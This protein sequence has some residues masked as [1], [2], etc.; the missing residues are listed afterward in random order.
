MKQNSLLVLLIISLVAITVGLKISSSDAG[1]SH[2]NKKDLL[3]YA[4]A[5]VDLNKINKVVI[6]TATDDQSVT[7]D[8]VG[9]EWRVKEG[10]DYPANV[11]ALTEFL[12]ELQSTRVVELKTAKV[13]HHSKLNLAALDSPN[14]NA[15][16]L[17]LHW[18]GNEMALL[19]GKEMGHGKGRYVRFEDSPQTYLVDSYLQ[20]SDSVNDWL[21]PKVFAVD[22]SD[23]R[24]VTLDKAGQVEFSALRPLKNLAVE[25]KASNEEN[26]TNLAK[27][28]VEQ[29]LN[30]S[31]LDEK[32]DSEK[33]V[34]ADHF[35]LV[36]DEKVDIELKSPSIIDG[37]VRNLISLELR[38]VEQRTKLDLLKLTQ[39]VFVEYQSKLGNTGRLRVDFY[40]SDDENL[41]FIA[42]DNSKWLIE[43][44]KNDYNKLAIDKNDLVSNTES[45]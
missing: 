33:S 31:K 8:L 27:K 40:S 35:E 41:Y 4:S 30:L 45:E 43:I 29:T 37:F 6:E 3:S 19:I 16:R 25:D 18:P 42:I 1:S 10:F 24:K 36:G 34:L 28:T 38:G 7:I 12:R 21:E 9:N 44:A 13:E 17:V 20:L 26:I 2:L 39:S 11:N 15:S 23:I 22:Y 14:S 32:L 5:K